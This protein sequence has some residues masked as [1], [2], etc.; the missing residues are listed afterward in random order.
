MTSNDK[1]GGITVPADG[2][3]AAGPKLA[4]R[5]ADGS[6]AAADPAVT[7]PVA[8]SADM[9]SEVTESGDAQ[10]LVADPA[11]VAATGAEAPEDDTPE[12]EPS[13]ST[14]ERSGLEETDREAAKST[15][16][17][18][19]ARPGVSHVIVLAAERYALVGLLVAV[20]LFF[21]FLPASSETFPTAA[22]L[23]ILAANQA[24]T[25]LLALAALIPLVAGHFDFS[26]GASAATASVLCAGLMQNNH[27]PLALA[28]VVALAAGLGI[29]LVNG[30]AVAWLKM[31]AFVSTLATATVLGGFIQWY[32]HGQSIS[33][34]IS[35]AL[36][37]FGSTTWLGIPR[38]VFLVALVAA[39]LWYVLGQTPYG[40]SLYAIGE[41]PRAARLVGIST[42]GYP[43]LAFA[44][45]GL[46]AGIAG[47]VLTARTAGA[48]A[49]NG[50]TMLFPALAAV[51]LGATAI[52]PGR[53]NVFG[54]VFGVALVAV[55]V[56][57]LTLAGT[58]DWVNPV[59]NGGALA[60]AVGLSTYL[61]R[62]SGKAD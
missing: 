43:L 10:A 30:V 29:G 50:T 12:E 14:S 21:C 46:V 59:F 16:A 42:R 48:T 20:A 47:V 31:N 36:I 55:S 13:A 23:R 39:A 32:A 3:T 34:N 25:L 15:A 19:T 61:R 27:A 38:P 6:P 44:G 7:E 1:G 53:F 24:V 18:P 17:T 41:N 4:D 2:A 5:P 11:V 37:D 26:V 8:D 28:V 45:A 22:N 57:G 35:T 62:R 52:R 40:R 9:E 51:F 49:D 33:N 54:T 60:V 58:S 56:S